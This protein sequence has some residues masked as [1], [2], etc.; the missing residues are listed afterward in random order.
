MC[1]HCAAIIV[2][3][4]TGAKIPRG[5]GKADHYSSIFKKCPLVVISN[6]DSDTEENVEAPVMSDRITKTTIAVAEGD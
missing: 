2:Y 3:F 6:E 5:V 4:A 1:S